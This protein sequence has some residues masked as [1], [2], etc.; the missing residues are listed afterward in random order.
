MRQ[1][2]QIWLIFVQEK[3]GTGCDMSGPKLGIV[4][5]PDLFCG[6]LDLVAAALSGVVSISTHPTAAAA[7][8]VFQ[9]AP[10]E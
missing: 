3:T 5:V 1:P 7:V 6:A 10:F 2:G 4:T 9:K 8:S